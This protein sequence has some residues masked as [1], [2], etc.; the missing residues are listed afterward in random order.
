[1]TSPSGRVPGRA[2]E[3]SRDGFGIDSGY[4][5]LRGFLLGS[6]GFLRDG[7]YMGEEAESESAWWGQTY[8]RCGQPWACAW[9]LS[10]PTRAP[11]TPPLRPYILRIGK[12]L[13]TREEIHEEF[14]SR[15]QRRTHLGRVLKLFPAPCRREKSSPEAST[16]PCLPPR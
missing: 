15:R 6:L 1:M 4:V 7:E 5:T 16:S 12:T 8:P 9:P 10:G 13:D 3:P 11:P 14:R 2:S